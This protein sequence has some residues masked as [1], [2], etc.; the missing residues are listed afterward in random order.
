M[1]TSEKCRRCVYRTWV[2]E[3]LTE[4][5]CYYIAIE[6]KKRGCP[7]GDECTQFIEGESIMKQRRSMS[8]KRLGYD[9]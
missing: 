2:G 8:Y 7:S 3:G 6:R 1:S 5:A 9:R 4:I